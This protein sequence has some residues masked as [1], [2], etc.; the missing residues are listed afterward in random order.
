M[1]VAA[2]FRKA[3]AEFQMAS[4]CPT[5]RC[6][7]D[8]WRSG[9]SRPLLGLASRQFCGGVQRAARR[10]ER[11]GGEAGA[12]Q[13]RGGDDVE[14]AGFA[15]RG[16]CRIRARRRHEQIIR[17]EALAAG[18]AKPADAPHVHQPRL[19]LGQQQRASL[20]RLVIARAVYGRERG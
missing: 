19:A 9:D 10:A 4:A 3:R 18:A 6:V 11:D 13:Q 7:V 17:L 16:G 14:R 2:S 8:S 1:A 15:R 5:M 12:E 20:E